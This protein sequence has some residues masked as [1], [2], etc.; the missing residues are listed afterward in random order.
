MEDDYG[1]E[2]CAIRK[3]LVEYMWMERRRGK[4]AVLAKD[5]IRVNGKIYDLEYYEK[6]YKTGTGNTKRKERERKL[7]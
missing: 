6:N 5:K 4:Y 3:K 7:R 2:I 1:P